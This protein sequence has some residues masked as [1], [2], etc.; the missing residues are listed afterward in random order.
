MDFSDGD[1]LRGSF[2]AGREPAIG[3]SSLDRG[4]ARRVAATGGQRQHGER[5]RETTI[6]HRDTS[7]TTTAL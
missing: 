5:D 7:A 4:T 2:G 1:M 6:K 3:D